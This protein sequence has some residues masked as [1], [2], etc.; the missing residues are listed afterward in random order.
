MKTKTRVYF[1]V[2]N[3]GDDPSVVSA[4]MRVPPTDAWTKGQ[5]YDARFPGALRTH[6]RWALSS[7]LDE[8]K[9]VEEHFAAL[10]AALETRRNEVT[11][12]AQRFT[13][14][15]TVV[16]Y[17]HDANPQFIIEPD[18]LRRFADLGVPV[19]FDQL[20]ARLGRRLLGSAAV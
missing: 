14:H 13:V 5:P 6:S 2:F 15:V 4:L 10:L 18:T 3:F 7:G 9:P 16:Q 19:Y 1:G 17:L 20:L 11:L 8:E 12:V